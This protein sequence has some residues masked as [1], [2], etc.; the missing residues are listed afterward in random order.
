MVLGVRREN[1][2]KGERKTEFEIDTCVQ[3][4]ARGEGRSEHISVVILECFLLT[5]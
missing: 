4:A 1:I 2:I 3:G 5:C